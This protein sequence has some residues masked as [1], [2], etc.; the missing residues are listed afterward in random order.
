MHDQ[1]TGT[2]AIKT[3]NV[4]T[5][6]ECSICGVRND[7]SKTPN[8][9]FVNTYTGTGPAPGVW[10]EIDVTLL[11]VPEDAKAVFLSGILI[12]THGTTVETGNLTVSL[13]RYGDTL[14]PGNYIGQSIECAVGSGQRSN[15]SSWVP[16]NG[17]RFEFQWNR[18]TQGQW[19]EHC[20]YGIN[21]ALQQYVR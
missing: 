1:T 18:G 21:L 17:G 12:I 14:N 10:H 7:N 2:L 19:P 15:M 20:S 11:G 16:L 5:Q 6:I 8:C 4:V 13:R 9:I 3:A